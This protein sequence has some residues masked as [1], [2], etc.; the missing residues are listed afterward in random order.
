M[1]RKYSKSNASNFNE[2]DML[3][4]IVTVKKYGKCAGRDLNPHSLR[5]MTLNHACLPIPAPAPISGP[6]AA[7]IHSKAGVY[8]NQKDNRRKVGT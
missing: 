2:F 4:K 6:V 3:K 7:K 1:T 5:H 8:G